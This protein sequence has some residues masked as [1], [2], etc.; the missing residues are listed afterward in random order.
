M[1]ALFEI[2]QKLK[3]PKTRTNNFAK[4]KYRSC[5][6]IFEAVKP[7]LKEANATLWL[8]DEILQMG[9]RFYLVAT[10][11]LQDE[12]G[13]ITTAK[14]WARE[15]E[16]KSGNDPAQ[17]TGAASSYA[18]KYALNALF[19]IDDTKDFDTD[20]YITEQKQRTSPMA[21][22]QATK[23]ATVSQVPQPSRGQVLDLDKHNTPQAI[24]DAI[25]DY[26]M[27]ELS[28]LATRLQVGNPDLWDIVKNE[29]TKRKQQIQ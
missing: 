8:T 13:N 9:D 17:I 29:F 22:P 2:Q 21:T 26:N 4:Y 24:K 1:N 11:H 20:E 23:P 7:C 25:Q 15:A 18:R 28:D 3:A 12:D 27:K 14:G 10:A 6:D 16:T 19:L 5:E